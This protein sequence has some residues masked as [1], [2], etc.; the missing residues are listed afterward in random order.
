MNTGWE[1]EKVNDG[2]KGARRHAH[3]MVEYAKD[4]LEHDEPWKLWE[5]S[6]DG[7]TWRGGFKAHLCWSKD[8]H[9]RRRPVELSTMTVE[10]PVFSEPIKVQLERFSDYFIP[11]PIG[12][13]KYH[14]MNS[15][16]DFLRLEK[17]YV[18]LSKEH[19]LQHELSIRHLN[20]L[21]R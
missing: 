19:A 6:I 8:L 13:E 5:Y 9:Y 4:A 14:W 20:N 1:D 17:G 3:L 18:H 2:A 16:I 7:I 15:G 10:I 11:S 21:K 12:V